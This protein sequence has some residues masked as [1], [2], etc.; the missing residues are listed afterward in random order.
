[1][2][3]IALGEFASAFFAGDLPHLGWVSGRPPSGGYR[4]LAQAFSAGESRADAYMKIRQGD[5]AILNLI[6]A[7]SLQ[8]GGSLLLMNVDQFRAIYPEYQSASD[9]AQ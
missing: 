1:M 3:R 8:V 9:H 5:L 7:T 2:V 4:Q 6:T